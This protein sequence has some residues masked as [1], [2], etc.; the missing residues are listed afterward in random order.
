MLIRIEYAGMLYGEE[1]NKEEKEENIEKQKGEERDKYN[2]P[3][4]ISPSGNDGSLQSVYTCLERRNLET[5]DR[6]RVNVWTGR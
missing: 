6:D 1:E 5:N 3:V 2:L 4:E